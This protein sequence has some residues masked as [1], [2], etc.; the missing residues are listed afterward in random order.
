MYMMSTGC[1]SWLHL[2]IQAPWL[3]GAMTLA[4]FATQ[5]PSNPGPGDRY[6]TAGSLTRL[7]NKIV[8]EHPE[9]ATEMVALRVNFDNLNAEATDDQIRSVLVKTDACTDISAQD[10]SPD[11]RR[12]VA[13]L[14]SLDSYAR[15]GPAAAMKLFRPPMKK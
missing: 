4:G 1:S 2:A 9:L 10:L 11:E 7:Q 15:E 5:V 12:N 6:G 3:V 13:W 14:L 8:A